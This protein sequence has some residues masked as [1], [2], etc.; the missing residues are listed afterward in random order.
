MNFILI[1]KNLGGDVR[2]EIWGFQNKE[3]KK[4]M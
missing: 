3:D 2:E 4:D 1:I